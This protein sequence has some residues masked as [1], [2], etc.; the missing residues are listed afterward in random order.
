LSVLSKRRRA[1][2]SDV[3]RI[4]DNTQEPYTKMV[5]KEGVEPSRGVASRDFESRASAHSATSARHGIIL[6]QMPC[7]C[8]ANGQLFLEGVSTCD[9]RVLIAANDRC[10]LPAV[11]R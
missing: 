10:G 5:P 6:P 4:V 11:K 2:T 7:R 9:L 1:S 3:L 8:K